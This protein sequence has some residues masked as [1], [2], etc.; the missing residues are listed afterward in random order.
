MVHGVGAALRYVPIVGKSVGGIVDATGHVVTGTWVWRAGS[1]EVF[2]AASGP[3]AAAWQG[4]IFEKPAEGSIQG[5]QGG[6]GSR[7]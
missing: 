1:W 5:G 3:R 7:G 2:W 6:P 4:V